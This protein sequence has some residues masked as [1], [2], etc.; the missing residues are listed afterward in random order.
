MKNPKKSLMQLL[1]LMPKNEKKNIKIN[2]Y[3]K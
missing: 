1:H 3:R 2:K